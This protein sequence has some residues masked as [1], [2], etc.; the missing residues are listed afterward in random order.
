VCVKKKAGREKRKRWGR[1]E[2]MPITKRR[3]A[4]DADGVMMRSRRR[5]IFNGNFFKDKNEL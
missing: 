2:A 5:K 4:A 3:A 1:T